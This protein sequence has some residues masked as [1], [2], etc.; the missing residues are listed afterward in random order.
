MLGFLLKSVSLSSL[1]EDWIES[2]KKNPTGYHANQCLAYKI[3]CKFCDN[4]S[5]GKDVDKW[6]FYLE[7][8]GGVY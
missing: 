1:S 5:I 7:W 8:H 3:E 6:K 2:L 4:C